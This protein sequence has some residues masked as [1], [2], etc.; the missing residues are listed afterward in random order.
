MRWAALSTEFARPIH[1]ILA[2]FGDEVVHFTLESIESSQY[3][4]GHY[5][6]KPEKIKLSSP[7]NYTEALRNAYV[8]ADI[9]ERKNIIESQ[10]TKKARERGGRVLPDQELLDIVTNLVEYPMPVLGS[11]DN[12]FLELPKEILITAMREHQKYFAVIDEN[13]NLMPYFIAVNNTKVKDAT[14]SAHGHERVIRA[15]LKDAQFFYNSDIKVS[16]ETRTEKLK[17]VLFQA[18]LGTMYEKIMRVQKLAGFIAR[19]VQ[20]N[21]DIV[22][23]AERAALLCKND[24]VSQVVGEFPKLQ[25]IM[26]RVYALAAGEPGEV[27]QAI[28]EHYQPTHSGGAVP[29]TF[30]GAILSIADKADSICGCFSTGLMPTGASDPYALRRQGIGI[31]QI[32]LNKQLSLSLNKIIEQSVKQFVLENNQDIADTSGKVYMFLRDRMSHL[33]A[34]QGFSKDVIAAVVNVS[35][36]CVP[37]VWNKVKALEELKAAPDFRPLAVAFKRVVNIIK[38]SKISEFGQ[39]D[40]EIFEKESESRLFSACLEIQQ[41]VSEHLKNGEFNEAL[42]EIASLKQPVDVFFDQVMVMAEDTGVRSNRLALLNRIA[43]LFEKF[44]DFSKIS[45]S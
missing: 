13:Q 42:L 2:L 6:M 12:V 4:Y 45:T 8:F 35:A 7:D 31:I 20:Q 14:L 26:G 38:K 15:R 22:S 36:D 40:P 34:D 23:M 37:D 25:G 43:C 30:T 32:M 19:D 27:A 17:K 41:K 1:Y 33:L 44:A 10:I 28:E 9:Q 39:V 18:K 3:T 21:S 16:S 11:F 29:K 24:L 5:F